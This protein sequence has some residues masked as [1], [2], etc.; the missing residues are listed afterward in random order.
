MRVFVSVVMVSAMTLT[1]CSGWRDSG[2]NPR[3]W[4]GGSTSTRVAADSNAQPSSPSDRQTGNPLIEDA[5]ADVLVRRNVSV[6]QRT[7]ILRR[8]NQT[9]IYEGTLIAEVTDLTVEQVPTGAIIRV[10]G[11]PQRE[12]A[13]DVR[14][15]RVNEDGPIDGIMEYTLNA[16]QPV[17]TRVGL[18][19]TREVKAGAFL[20]NAELEE[21]REIRVRA[22]R[23]VRSTRR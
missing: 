6:I 10:T 14:L 3:N 11:L 17:A 7:G 12:G 1:A 20:S 16:Y 9:V 21:I 13:F 2:A 19:R 15:L 22:A 5:G 8:R 18:T 23:N 4:F